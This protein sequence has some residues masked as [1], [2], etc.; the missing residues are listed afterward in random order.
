M[1]ILNKKQHPIR[2]VT[3]YAK[4]KKVAYCRCWQSNLMPYCDGAH[5]KYNQETGDSLGPII[6]DSSE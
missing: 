6:V 2:C 3:K 4:D 5:K 1:S